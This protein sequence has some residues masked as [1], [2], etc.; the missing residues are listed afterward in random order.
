MA[1][2]SPRRRR[3]LTRS[4]THRTRNSRKTSTASSAAPVNAARPEDAY[5]IALNDAW[6]PH[7]VSDFTVSIPYADRGEYFSLRLLE[8]L[9]QAAP[10]CCL[11]CQVE[12]RATLHGQQLTHARA[13]I[14]YSQK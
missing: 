5:A 4:S 14:C 3:R 1:S 10:A 12:L 9:K 2:S 6:V 13:V 11:E 8:T 7:N